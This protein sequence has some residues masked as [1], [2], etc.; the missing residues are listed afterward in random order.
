LRSAGAE[1][2][3]GNAL[4][5]VL[6]WLPAPVRDVR[7]S[8]PI[9]RT[10]LELIFRRKLFWGL[11]ALAMLVFLLFFFGQYLMA[12]AVTQMGQSEVRV[13][14]LGM[15]KPHELVDHLRRVLRMDG[16]AETYR[17]FFSFESHMVMIVLALAGSVLIGNDLRFGSLPFYLSKPLSRRH[18][19]LGKAMAV[20]VFINLLTTLPAL[21]LFVQFGFLEPGRGQLRWSFP[22]L[23]PLLLTV[24]LIWWGRTGR[25]H[26]GWLLA[27]VG[28][29]AAELAVLLTGSYFTDKYYLALGILGYGAILTVSLT[30]VLLATASW[31]E[32]TVPL[33]MAW[34]TLFLF[35]RVLATSLVDGLHQ[36]ARWRLLD[37]WNSAALLGN[38]CLLIDPATIRP[39]PQPAWYEAAFILG[40]VCVLCLIYLILRIRAVE[41]VK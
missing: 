18:Y 7:T 21:L 34:A 4:A 25:V 36:D 32:K 9:A 3:P 41:I 11:Y 1:E 37:L 35:C 5:L 8:W 39:S 2:A 14:G 30:L 24:I 17:N 26:G 31:L 19:L 20:A 6:G 23:A 12:W 22:I 27:A 33:I 28:V 40:S 29:S 13:G 16:S 10:S 38:Y 15:A